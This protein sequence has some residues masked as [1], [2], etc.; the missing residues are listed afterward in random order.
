MS[1][2]QVMCHGSEERS[3]VVAGFIYH[4]FGSSIRCIADV[5]GGQG[6]RAGIFV[7]HGGILRPDRKGRRAFVG[8]SGGFRDFAP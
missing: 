7:R 2:Q 8:A 3:E 5:A 1:R 6:L 4:T